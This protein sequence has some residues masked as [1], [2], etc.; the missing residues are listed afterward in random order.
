MWPPATPEPHNSNQLPFASKGSS[1]PPREKAV[2]S[3]KY[4]FPQLPDP[5]Q[6]P[7]ARFLYNQYPNFGHHRLAFVN[8]P[9]YEHQ[10]NSFDQHAGQYYTRVQRYGL[11]YAEA[12]EYISG[13]PTGSTVPSPSALPGLS[14][15]FPKW[16]PCG[17]EAPVIIR[18]KPTSFLGPRSNPA[19]FAFLSAKLFR[20]SRWVRRTGKPSWPRI[21]WPKQK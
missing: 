13:A 12:L 8:A 1:P 11:G 17:A 14:S 2:A 19:K 3:R 20:K 18:P 6:Y 15:K 4:P 10:Y 9:A 5:A 21:Q 7:D 16:S